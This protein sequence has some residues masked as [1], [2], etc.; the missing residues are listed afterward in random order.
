MVGAGAAGLSAAY[1]LAPRGYEVTWPTR[2]TSQE[3][4][5][6][7]IDAAG[8]R[9]RCSTPRSPGSWRS[10]SP[11]W[12]SS[13]WRP[14]SRAPRELK[15]SQ[16]AGHADATGSIAAACTSAA[17]RAHCW[18][19]RR[20]AL[21]AS[22]RR[23]LPPV[24]KGKVRSITICASRAARRPGRR[25]RRGAIAE[26]QRCL[27]CGACFEC[28]SCGSTAPIRRRSGRSTRDEPYR[29]K[30]EFCQGGN[31]CAEQCPSSYIETL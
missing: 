21:P 26:S 19:P 25:G 30:L 2:M 4:N 1:Q 8:S 17:C 13:I 24:D 7:G 31:K 18:T 23:R 28:D 15:T 11:S 20:A 29:F 22:R 12:A 27:S 14:S 6:D 3:A 10:A 16:R 5:C 9:A